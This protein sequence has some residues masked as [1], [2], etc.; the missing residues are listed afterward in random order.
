[1][2]QKIII[3]A[4]P[5][6]GD[7][8]AIGLALNSPEFDVVGL[9]ATAGVVSGS[10]AA[11]NLMAV[12]EQV[13]PQK[14]PR[15]GDASFEDPPEKPPR[16][17]AWISPRELHGESGLGDMK[18][19]V[20]NLHHSHPA[21]KIMNELVHTFPNEVTIVTLGPLT[22]LALACDR[23]PE[24]SS[25]VKGVVCLGGASMNMGDI[26]PAAEFNI[27]SDPEAARTVMHCPMTLT[28]IPL[29]VSRQ[30]ALTMNQFM[31]FPQDK[32]EGFTG[33]VNRLVPF[34][35]R[36]HHQHLGMEGIA[37][38]EVT[39]LAAVARPEWFET[40]RIAVNIE[41]QGELTRGMTVFDFRGTQRW[42]GNIDVVRSLHAQSVV[43]FFCHQAMK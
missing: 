41:T 30:P 19:R 1:M 38:P 27:Y 37:L 16:S 18:G 26:T 33:L 2:V 7:A 5:G 10:Q 9:T 35:F 24:F 20:L 32:T 42:Q 36:T 4:D 39:A 23:D 25:L 34:Y 6:I 22:N 14:H 3:D 17:G 15:M 8:L 12:I 31:R 29:E 43:D 11:K 13:D 21:H 28:V 40:E